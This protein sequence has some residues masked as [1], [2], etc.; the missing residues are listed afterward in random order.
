MRKNLCVTWAL[1]LVLLPAGWARAEDKPDVS[2]LLEKGIK[3][4]GGE[5]RLEK[6]KAAT[7]KGKGTFHAGGTAMEYTGEWAMQAPDRY[8]AI[9][10]AEAN[11]TKYKRVRVLDGDKGWTKA[12]DNP[13]EE[14]NADA[15]AE[16]RRELHA[17]WL[18]RL[19]PLRDGSFTM[20]VT[21]TTKVGELPAVGL[22]VTAKDGRKF[23]LY[24][25]RDSGLLLKSETRIKPVGASEEVKQEVL[26][27]DYKDV[28]GI[29]HAAKIIVKRDG[30]TI[31]EQEVT[32]Y[33]PMEK[34]DESMFAKPS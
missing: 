5:A 20:A 6:L 7:W 12:D 24:L 34:L 22:E 26:Y 1:G 18:T 27:A 14:M 2:A 8:R 10:H 4:L 16:I 23:H 17:Q 13:A 31:L 15:V 9:V 32:E 21:G 3:A 30:R 28:G 25:D 29:K 11:G 33:Q 19:V